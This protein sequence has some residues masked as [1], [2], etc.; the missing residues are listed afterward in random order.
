MLEDD[1][2]L[3]DSLHSN[4]RRSCV[5]YLR[6]YDVLVLIIMADQIFSKDTL[7][8]DMTVHAVTKKLCKTLDGFTLTHRVSMAKYDEA[9]K[10]DHPIP[11]VLAMGTFKWSGEDRE[12]QLYPSKPR[13][14]VRNVFSQV[15]T[16]DAYKTQAFTGTNPP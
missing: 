9:T 10:D 15:H 1:F 4:L 12:S 3:M 6:A 16:L 5:N 8:R 14:K 13:E 2:D 7:K 11:C